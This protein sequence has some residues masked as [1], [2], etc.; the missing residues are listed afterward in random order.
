MCC[1]GNIPVSKAYNVSINFQLDHLDD[2]M[3]RSWMAARL[4]VDIY[5]VSCAFAKSTPSFLT[6]VMPRDWCV[7]KIWASV[8]DHKMTFCLLWIRRFGLDLTVVQLKMVIP[9]V[10]SL[11]STYKAKVC[12]RCLVQAFYRQWTRYTV[13]TYFSFDQLDCHLLWTA[14]YRHLSFIFIFL[15]SGYST[16]K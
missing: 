7:Y 12:I 3:G 14:R 8:I 11:T 5:S 2:R 10:Y 15:F 16:F 1:G 6:G 4:C 9:R 13:L